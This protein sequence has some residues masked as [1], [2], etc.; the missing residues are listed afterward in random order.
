MTEQEQALL[1]NEALARLIENE[2]AK[3]AKID[4]E[5]QKREA[6][7]LAEKEAQEQAQANYNAVI[8]RLRTELVDITK[9][10]VAWR[11]RFDYVLA[12]MQ[13]M[14]KEAEVIQA[15]ISNIIN[16]VK[17]AVY[18]GR[19]SGALAPAEQT[20]WDSIGGD[21]PDLDAFPK[22]VLWSTYDNVG[23]FKGRVAHMVCKRR[24]YTTRKLLDGRRRV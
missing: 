1:E 5:R 2:I 13:A 7:A 22:G 19:K 14:P 20:V 17:E 23:G 12:E 11:K 6:H 21:N 18:L 3:Q 8:D 24:P 16:R 10:Q 4:L 9:R 15:D